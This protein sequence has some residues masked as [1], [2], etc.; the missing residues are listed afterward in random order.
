M[1]KIVIGTF[2]KDKFREI[3]DILK[4]IDI[5]LLP[6]FDFT[7]EEVEEAGETLKEN[8]YI[9]AKYAYEVTGI[10]SVS[11]DTGLEVFALNGKPGVYSARYA[12]ENATYEDNVRKLL[13]EMKKFEDRRAAFKTVVCFY[14][15]KQALYFT[16][17]TEGIILK[18]LRGS[19]GFGYDPIFYVESMGKTYAQMGDKLKNKISHRYKAFVKFKEFLKGLTNE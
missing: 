16:G 2:N 5:E 10:P 9:K 1:N 7:D 19:S 12:G 8:A 4:D 6:L 17:E 15:G 3:K 11:D 18:E 13:D 14:D